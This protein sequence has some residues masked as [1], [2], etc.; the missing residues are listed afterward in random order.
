LTPTTTTQWAFVLTYV[1]L[2]ITFLEKTKISTQFNRMSVQRKLE[3]G[4]FDNEVVPVAVPQRKGDPIIV[5]KDEEFTNVK[6]E[7]SQP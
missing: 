3:A 2:N 4:K 6:I 5:S 1:L 7:K